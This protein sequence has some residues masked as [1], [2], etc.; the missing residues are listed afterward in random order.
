M[1]LFAPR[2]PLNARESSTATLKRSRTLPELSPWRLP[3]LEAETQSAYRE[4]RAIERRI[5]ALEAEMQNALGKNCATCWSA[6]QPSNPDKVMPINAEARERVKPISAEAQERVAKSL[7]R[8]KRAL[9]KL[10]KALQ[11]PPL[12]I[13]SEEDEIK[14][15]TNELR[16]LEREQQAQ[17]RQLAHRGKQVDAM[18]LR[19]GHVD[20]ARGGTN[21][22]EEVEEERVLAYMQRLEIKAQRALEDHERT[23]A[24]V[25]TSRAE[26]ER[27]LA[28]LGLSTCQLRA[29]ADAGEEAALRLPTIKHAAEHGGG[30]SPSAALFDLIKS[31][32]SQQRAL[33]GRQEELEARTAVI[34]ARLRSVRSRVEAEGGTIADPLQRYFEADEAA[35]AARAAR[36]EKTIAAKTEAAE[37]ARATEAAR[38]AEAEAEAAE[39][40]A[41]VAEAAEEAAVSEAT[42][43]AE[44]AAKAVEAAKAMRAEIAEAGG[45]REAA[46][47]GAAKAAQ[48]APEYDLNAYVVQRN[49][50]KAARDKAKAEEARRAEAAA[51][52]QKL[53]IARVI[54]RMRIKPAVLAFQEWREL[55]E[56][57]KLE[58]ANPEVAKAKAKAK[59]EAAAKAEEEEARVASEARA[60]EAGEAAEAAEP[61]PAQGTAVVEEAAVEEEGLVGTA[62]SEVPMAADAVGTAAVG[63][64]AKAEEATEE[65]EA[66]EAA[67]EVES[68]E[69]A[70]A[71]VAKPA[72]EMVVAT[73]EVARAF[74]EAED[75]VAEIMGGLGGDAMGQDPWASAEELEAAAEV[76][77]IAQELKQA[78]QDEALTDEARGSDTND[79]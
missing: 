34:L 1:V 76:L 2:R 69:A 59:A 61:K 64:V 11:D 57:A 40:E 75:A 65:E 67:A 6:A 38:A 73:E 29:R 20:P 77:L 52:N 36:A 39:E 7:R 47:A 30:E 31:L 56:D 78:N 63:V 51:I 13:A 12:A 68:A 48:E 26:W 62:A 33:R 4:A 5:A 42:A 24:S 14:Q 19:H 45:R 16:V 3:T 74:E 66:A 21:R 23:V 60:E 17:T 55:V 58:R 46:G 49:E 10:A 27:W 53:K 32:D 25:A 71:E 28:L 15:L 9:E 22:A 50:E 18:R 43:A 72:E 54:A 44:A 8:R 70:T 41:R 37:A 79:T 35:K